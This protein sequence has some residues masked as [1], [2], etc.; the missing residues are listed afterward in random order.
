MSSSAGDEAE[1][2]QRALSGDGTAFAALFRKHQSRV[3]RRALSL[4][5]Q[6]H[7]AEDVTAAAF[8]E[9]W[10]KRRSV[11]LVQGGVLP[12]LLV[13]TVNVARN[14]RRGTLRYRRLI[15]S[16]PHGVTENAESVAVANLEGEA[17]GVR[18]SEALSRVTKADAALLVL[19]ALDGLSVTD[20]ARTLGIK[21]GTARMRLQRARRRLQ[22]DLAFEPHSGTHPIA[23]GERA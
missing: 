11:R 18:L 22:A 9:L 20:A 10:R 16:L 13:T 8:F 4:V 15:S 5:G 1:T 7:D 17:L 6:V 2:W 12:W 3:Y 14:H 21:P 23:E 19:T